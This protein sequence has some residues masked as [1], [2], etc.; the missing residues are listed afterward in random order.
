MMTGD[1]MPQ[2]KKESPEDGF[3]FFLMDT[4]K[5]MQERGAA[6]ISERAAFMWEN[7]NSKKLAIFNL[8]NQ[9]LLQINKCTAAR[10]CTSLALGVL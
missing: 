7:N 2:T 9:I 6:F 5:K 1:N 10:R 3:H 4:Q 8:T